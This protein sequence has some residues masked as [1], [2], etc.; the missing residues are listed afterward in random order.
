MIDLSLL[1]GLGRVW[2][3]GIHYL[4]PQQNIIC[5]AI[6]ARAT[7]HHFLIWMR[8]T[9]TRWLSQCFMLNIFFYQWTW[10]RWIL[11]LVWYRLIPH[12]SQVLIYH[13]EVLWI[14][15]VFVPGYL[16]CMLHNFHLPAKACIP[17]W[18]I[19]TKYRTI[20]TESHKH[21]LFCCWCS[22]CLHIRLKTLV[23]IEKKVFHL[24]GICN[25]FYVQ[26][27]NSLSFRGNVC[28]IGMSLNDPTAKEFNDF[29]TLYL[30]CT[31]LQK[32]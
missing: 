10:Q 2:V 16:P 12:K 24:R 30:A 5:V 6:T 20:M 19:W 4:E 1:V 11:C 25:V 8:T 18:I 13:I 23:F 31:S 22:Y 29:S 7:H 28:H 27:L 32:Y 17:L 3:D 9:A 21:M 14:L 15:I 26:Q